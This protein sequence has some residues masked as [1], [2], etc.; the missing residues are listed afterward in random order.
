MNPTPFYQWKNEVQK[1]FSELKKW[2]SLGLAI[3]SYGIIKSRKSQASLIAEEIPEFGKAATV[4]RRIQRWIA[5]P[6]IQMDQIAIHWA[7]WV[8]SG[9][10]GKNVFLLVD[11][12]KISDRIACMMISLALRK[13]AIPLIWRCYRA[14]SSEDYPAEGQVQMIRAMLGTLKPILPEDKRVILE[15]DRGIGNS[16]NLMREVKDVGIEFLFR[17]NRAAIFTSDE[18]ISLSL[19]DIAQRGQIWQETGTL[20]TKHRAV[21]DCTVHILWDEDCDEPWCLATSLKGMTGSEYKLRVWQEESFRDLKS[22]G[23]Q[24]Q[25]SLLRNPE[26][27]ER[28]LLPMAL[29]YAW[30]LSLGIFLKTW[31]KKL[32]GRLTALENTQNTAFFGKAYAY[33]NGISIWNQERYLF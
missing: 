26:I 3:I 8:L 25:S 18:G 7:R 16:S 11:E 2:Q 22:A 29:A 32:V 9:Y 1:H 19:Q 12:T 5:N 23:W 6:R 13:R 27:A 17:V 15:A 14:N 20:F 31:M 21:K 30:C 33:S 28:V 10:V 24:W 4:E